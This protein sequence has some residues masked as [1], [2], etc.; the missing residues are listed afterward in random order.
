MKNQLINK[1]SSKTQPSEVTDVVATEDVIELNTDASGYSRLGWLIVLVGVIGFIVWASFAPLDQGVP[2]SGN[3]IAASNRKVVQAPSAA[4]VDEILVKDG[5]VVK[6]GQVL[7]RMNKV[8]AFS[9]LEMARAQTYSAVASLARLEAERDNLS[10]VVFPASLL[11]D[12][13]DPRAASL[14]ATQQQL[15]NA[16][17]SSMQSELR[18]IDENIEGLKIQVNGLKESMVTKK[19]Q[20]GF[21]KEQ[22]ESLRE[23]A[24]D[25]YIARNRLLDVERQYSQT[26]GSIAE[27]NGSIGKMQSQIAELGL[28]KVQRQQEYQK[29]IRAML[30]DT[31]KEVDALRARTMALE[32]DYENVEV[33]APVD[34]EIVSSSI[35]TVGAIVPSGF[36]LM[37]VVPAKD[38]LIVEGMLPVN[39]ID[40][41][42]KDLK[43]EL[44]FSAFNAK[45]TP[46]IHGYVLHVAADRS[47]DEKT[48]TP[49]YKVLA[50][51]TKEGMRALEEFQIRPGMPVQMVVITGERTMMNYLLGPI[52]TRAAAAMKEE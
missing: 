14:I 9:A 3:V 25:G 15:F 21:L 48:G 26:L 28:R 19:Q 43:V 6:A 24:K 32:R 51:V 8:A 20:M 49:Y 36:K 2:L 10:A 29:E 7:M 27:D 16:R 5:D 45:T 41:V 47:I 1:L 50:G 46:K 39:L 34:G 17:R 12:K 52:H 44:I 11:K 23:L 31:Q 42:H 4:T 40:K 18:A 13:N 37:E 35:Y 22:V 30:S 38:S 33:K